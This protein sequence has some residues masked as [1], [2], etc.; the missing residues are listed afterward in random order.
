MFKVK[1]YGAGSIGNHLSHAARTLGWDVTVC[2]LDPA[3]LARMREEIYPRRYGSWDDEIRLFT[4]DDSPRGGFD[5]IFIGTPPDTHLQLAFQAVSERPRA[6]VIEKPVCPPHL[7]GLHQLLDEIRSADIRAFVGYDHAVGQAACKVRELIA[8]GTIGQVKTID[9]EFREHWGGILA[10]HPWL[11]GPEA[12]YLGYWE[13]GGGAGGEHSHALHLWQHFAHLSGAGKV[14]DL[15]AQ[16]QYGNEGAYDEIC[17]LQLTT[18][19]GLVGRVVQDVITSPPRKWARLQ[20]STGAIEWHC[21]YNAEGDAVVIHTSGQEAETHLIAKTRPDDFIEELRFIESQLNGGSRDLSLDLERGLETMACIAAAHQS[22]RTRRSVRVDYEHRRDLPSTEPRPS[23]HTHQ[24]PPIA[25][26]DLFVLDLANNH[27]GS[28]DHG[29]RVI[30]ET[31]AIV[32]EK[33]VRAGIK[34]QFR[35]LDSFIHADFRDATVPKHIP[36]FLGTRLEQKDWAKLTAAVRD[37]GLVTICT[38]FDEPSVDLIEALDIEIIKIASCSADDWPLLER[39]AQCSRPVICSTGGLSLT[40]IDDLVSFFDHRRVTYALMHCVAIYP[41]PTEQMQLNQVRLFCERYPHVSIGF[42]THEDPDDCDAIQ[43]AYAMGARIFERH[44]GVETE[45]IS[46]NAYSSRPHQLGGW[47]EGWEK[48]RA[49]CGAGERG[50]A[51]QVETDS[52]NSLKRGVYLHKRVKSGEAIQPENVYFAMPLQEGQL[53]SGELREG[54]VA[55]ALI[56]SDAPVMRDLVQLPPQAKHTVL[57][58]AIH[59]ARAMLNMARISLGLDFEVEF[60]HHYGIENFPEVGALLIDYVN[61]SYCKKLIIQLP[62][63][64]HP[65]HFHKRKEETFIVLYGQMELEIDGIRKTL[66]PGEKQIVHQGIWHSFWTDTGVIFEE[67]SSTSFANDSFYEDK[68]I[69][70]VSRSARKTRVNH[71]GRYQ[72]TS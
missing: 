9:V 8:A 33:G 34:F 20:G 2:D 55:A 42:S 72:L 56:E 64:H 71:W 3:A 7:T 4:N 53:A 15:S 45:E 40:Q 24:S 57:Y 46:L 47:F 32:R 38:P 39:I 1:I 31:A 69:N 16:I 13:R 58:Q 5:L 35:E 51:P 62:G 37:E 60:S 29:L 6:V 21:G 26:D 23:S 17:A 63:Q 30:R 10:A 54:I 43:V 28:V 36:R 14:Q 19:T 67:I 27:Q 44:V 50:C 41:T 59:E 65:S 61:R 25:F 22:Q 70:R 48:A 68:A 49:L 11:S 18:E 12:S 52:L 66:H